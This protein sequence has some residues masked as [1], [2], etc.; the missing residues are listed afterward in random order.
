M[1]DKDHSVE[2]E[3]DQKPPTL[4]Q[5]IGSV[6]SAFIGIQNSKNKKRDFEHGNIKVFITVGIILTLVFLITVYTVVQT[7]LAK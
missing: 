5:V 4:L 1:T 2:P 3:D 6:L 7:V